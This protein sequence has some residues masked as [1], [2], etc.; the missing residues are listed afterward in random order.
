MKAVGNCHLCSSF[1]AL[2]FHFALLLLSNC[3]N[4]VLSVLLADIASTSDAVTSRE[5]MCSVGGV[6]GDTKTS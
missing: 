4:V 3:V 6:T 2:H 5:A 1:L